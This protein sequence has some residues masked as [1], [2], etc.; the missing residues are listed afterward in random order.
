MAVTFDEALAAYSERWGMVGLH[1]YR[2]DGDAEYP[3]FRSAECLIRVPGAMPMSR[4]LT[5]VDG[6]LT[7]FV[8]VHR[9]GAVR[10]DDAAMWTLAGEPPPDAPLTPL[11]AAL[12]AADAFLRAHAHP[13]KGP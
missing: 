4:D 7:L 5:E 2:H 10:D 8:M 3:P 11:P 12:D 13:T 9:D 1:L 6:A